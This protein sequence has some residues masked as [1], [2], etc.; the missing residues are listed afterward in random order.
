VVSALLITACSE[1][2]PDRA[3]CVKRADENFDACLAAKGSD[4]ALKRVRERETC[5]RHSTQHKPA[6]LD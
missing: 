4:C 2:E 1:R 5:D 3:S 6:A